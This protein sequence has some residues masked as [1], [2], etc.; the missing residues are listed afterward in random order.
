MHF[1][2]PHIVQVFDDPHAQH[3]HV[4]RASSRHRFESKG[5]VPRRQAK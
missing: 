1:I 5:R 4:K 2:S 3:H